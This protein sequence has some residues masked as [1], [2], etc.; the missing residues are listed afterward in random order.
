MI[1]LFFNANSFNI[2]QNVVG[3]DYSIVILVFVQEVLCIISCRFKF[4]DSLV[5]KKSC[6]SPA[7]TGVTLDLNAISPLLTTG[8]QT[9]SVI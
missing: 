6:F 4:W 8:S 9:Y 3:I 1:K 5:W 7:Q 2:G